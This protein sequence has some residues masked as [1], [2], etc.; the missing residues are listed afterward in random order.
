MNDKMTLK[1]TPL[2]LIH[3]NLSI[4]HVTMLTL[5]SLI[6]MIVQSYQNMEILLKTL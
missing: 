5:L 3:S 1:Y 2:C 4:L 6:F